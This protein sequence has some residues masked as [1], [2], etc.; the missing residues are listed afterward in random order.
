MLQRHSMS[1]KIKGSILAIA[2]DAQKAKRENPQTIDGTIGMLFDEGGKL[3]S[4]SS[5]KNT[6]NNLADM[7]NFSYSTTSGGAEFKNA[8]MNWTFREY[9]DEILSQMA[10]ECIATPGG[11]GA[12][13]IS[14]ANY[15]N[16]DEYLITSDLGWGNYSVIAYENYNK[17]LYYSLFD[18]NL[19][20]NMNSFKEAVNKSV[21]EQNRAFV[22]INDPCHNPTGFCLSHENWDEIISFLNQFTC[23]II[24]FL[25]MAYIDYLPMGLD[26]SRQV[27]RKFTCLNENI[28]VN[29]GFS[30]SKTFSVYGLR[31]GALIGLSKNKEYIREF[32]DANEYSARGR[33]SNANHGAITMVNKIMNDDTLRMKFEEELKEASLMLTTRANAFT[34]EALEVGLFHYPYR[35]GFF[36]T[37]PCKGDEVYEALKQDNVFVIPLKTGVRISLSALSLANIQGLAL[38]IKEKMK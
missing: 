37:I 25:D 38:K 17:I 24:L 33:W 4:F 9:K 6:L 12:I 19:Q 3:M 10:C 18:D 30:G 35:G 36:I 13:G 5:V 28:M 16:Y 8:I 31:L 21:L 14:I 1:K 23:P 29:L 26:Y 27:F 7:E 20:F 15:L 32:F 11:S 22:I 34:K 2:A